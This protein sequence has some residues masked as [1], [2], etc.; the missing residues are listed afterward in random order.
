M[1]NTDEIPWASEQEALEEWR[2]RTYAAEP[3]TWDELRAR[4]RWNQ[5]RLQLEQEIELQLRDDDG[6]QP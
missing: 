1:N 3:P 6:E 4:L 5:L 2:S